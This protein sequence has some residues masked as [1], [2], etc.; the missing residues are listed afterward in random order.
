MRAFIQT[1]VITTFV[2]T[3]AFQ[4]AHAVN[5]AIVDTGLDPAIL[6]GVI[7]P[8]SFDF[9]NNDNDASDES[10]NFHG[11][12]AGH[13]AIN[14]GSGITL[15]GIKA[16]QQATGTTTAILTAAFD[17]IATLPNVRVISHNGASISDTPLASLRANT[18]AG[19]IIVLQAGNFGGSSPVGDAAKAASLDNLAIVAGGVT[20]SGDEIQS[21]SNRA[22]NLKDY[23][24]MAPTNS[25]IT[26][27]NGTSMAVPRIAA[28]A[29]TL[30]DQFGFLS[31]QQVVQILFNTARDLGEPGADSIY[32]HGVLDL[33]AALSAAGSGTIPTAPDDGGGGGGG[34][35]GAIALVVGG[36]AAYAFLNKKEKLQRTVLVDDYGRAYRF[37]FDDRISV[38]DTR[39]DVFVLMENQKDDFET[40]VLNLS[41]NSYTQAFIVEQDFRPFGLTA[42]DDIVDQYISFLHRTN[43]P[44][45]Q[46]ALGLNSDLSNDFGALSLRTQKSGGDASQFYMSELF[47][48]PVLGYSSMGSS[49]MYGWNKNTVNHRF[50]MSVIDEQETNGLQSN[51]VLYESSFIQD[52]YHVGLQLGA[53]LEDGSFLGSANDSVLG[54]DQ[55]NTYYIGFNGAY[56]LTEK[57]SLLGGYF[58]GLSDVTEGRNSLLS[59][60]D[61]VRTEGFALGILI[62]DL[63]TPKGR[64]GIS[65]SS[66]LQ[67]VDGSATLT[68]PVSQDYYTGEIGFDSTDMSFRNG[69]Q[70]KVFEAYYNYDIS[71]RSSVFTHFSYTE[72]PL[73]NLDAAKD[74][75][76]FFGFKHRF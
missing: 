48:T 63:F 38:R 68:L 11:T 56:K 28:A 64:F 30:L 26:S 24:L 36:A 27:A 44:D 69:D 23:Y 49:F 41:K 8:D 14:S 65:Y 31:G 19:K 53:L 76:I 46:Y 37:N 15:T 4:T 22:G 58:Q 33:A 59:E 10:S 25:L 71:H 34:G 16:F 1:I 9:V 6:G 47:S 17:Y 35:A 52:N 72:N 54:V 57:V 2:F 32:G 5:I 7:S 62:D 40:V 39:P 3:S 45:F 13:V 43:N 29:A 55:T 21:F 42:N 75:T 61:G 60:V 73:S 12:A 70:E 67:T 20:P 51:S 50:G 74:R 18:R 66:P